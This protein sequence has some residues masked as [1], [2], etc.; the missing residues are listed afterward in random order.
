MPGRCWPNPHT[1]RRRCPTW[2]NNSPTQRGAGYFFSKKTTERLTA[3]AGVLPL[4]TT[5]RSTYSERFRISQPCL[6]ES[7][8]NA[9]RGS[10]E[11]MKYEY[12]EGPKAKRDF[13][14]A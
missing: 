1:S 13:E 4:A 6:R 5:E 8:S 12:A 2:R 3:A 10:F 14:N 7:A 11:E 9:R